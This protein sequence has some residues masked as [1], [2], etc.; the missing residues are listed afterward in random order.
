M[1]LYFVGILNTQRN[2]GLQKKNYRLERNVGL[3]V[4]THQC[5]LQST[6][7]NSFPSVVSFSQICGST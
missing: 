5:Q 2:K 7:E 6:L 4:L 3:A 1:L